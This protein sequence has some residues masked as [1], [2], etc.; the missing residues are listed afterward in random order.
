MKNLP[1]LQ[2]VK[3]RKAGIL[4]GAKL[5]KRLNWKKLN[6]LVP[7]VAQD[8]RTKEVLMVGFMNQEAFKKTLEEGIVTYY[9]RTRKQLWTKG[10]TSGNF[11]LVRE[12]LSDCDNDTLLIKVKQIGNVCH[13]GSKTCFFNKICKKKTK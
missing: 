7:A 1:K 4:P 3:F 13:T 12:I 9:S 10:K 2:P 6:G 5:F 8:Y 11:Q